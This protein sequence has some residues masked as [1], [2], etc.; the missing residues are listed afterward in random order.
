MASLQMNRRLEETFFFPV[1][2]YRQP[3]SAIKSAHC[4]GHKQNTGPIH[5]E[6]PPTI[7]WDDSYEKDKRLKIAVECMRD[8]EL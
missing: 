7:S 3:T 5:S 4:H 8:T 1:K 6:I 2:M